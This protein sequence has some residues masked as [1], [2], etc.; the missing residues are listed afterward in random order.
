[1]PFNPTTFS[2]KANTKGRFN[3]DIPAA[4]VAGRLVPR[5]TDVEAA[6]LGALMLEK[7]AFTTVCELITVL[8]TKP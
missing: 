4:D 1:M 8:S 6:V 2:R 5:A 3:T 7:D